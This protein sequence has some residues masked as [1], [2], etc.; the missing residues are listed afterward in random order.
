MIALTVVQDEVMAIANDAEERNISRVRASLWG[1]ILICS[2]IVAALFLFTSYLNRR[3]S[4]P[5]VRLLQLVEQWGDKNFGGQIDVDDS[6]QAAN[7]DLAELMTNFKK[8]LIAMRFGDDKWAHGSADKQMS[9][10][11]AALNLVQTS[12]NPAGVG[13]VFNNIALLSSHPD[14]SAAYPQ[15]DSREVYDAAIQSGI[16]LIRADPTN[17]ALHDKLAFRLLNCALWHMRDKPPRPQEAATTLLMVMQHTAS[18][19]T[20]A[21]IAQHVSSEV[22]ASGPEPE[23]TILKAVSTLI[24]AALTIAAQSPVI[25]EES[26]FIAD[27]AVA[28]C[29]IGCT[30]VDETIGLLQFCQ[31]PQLALW[32]LESV[33]TI[34]PNTLKRLCLHAKAGTSP[35]FTAFVDTVADLTSDRAG[36]E[37]ALGGATAMWRDL[38]GTKASLPKAMMFALDLSYSM[39]FGNPGADSLLKTCKTSLASILMEH[40]QI[41]DRAGLVTFADDVKVDIPLQLAGGEDSPERKLMLDKVKS[42]RTRGMTA[43][44]EAVAKGAELLQTQLADEPMTPKW[45]VALTDG[46]DNRSSRDAASRACATIAST[47]NLNVAIITVGDSIDMKVTKTF[48][49]AA[50]GA[51]N[52]AMLVQAKDGDEI[53]KAF[54]AVSAAMTGMVEV[55]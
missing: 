49:R 16:D 15:L 18:A 54:K 42:L 24:A 12:G 8:L 48:L 28:H 14:V 38:S 2:V 19:R 7:R 31:P 52:Q 17:P 11:F 36:G 45:L 37:V 29:D 30:L 39:D 26:D 9:N 6:R 20:M 44:Y 27:L 4:Q 23:P 13:T 47:P 40:V 50:E 35:A 33:P 5:I 51:G 43:F 46:A 1:S 25:F 32:A 34:S 22:V 53:A 10:N 41:R 3:F 55:L 21:T